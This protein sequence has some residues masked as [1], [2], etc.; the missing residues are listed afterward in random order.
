MFSH[1]SK[2]NFIFFKKNQLYFIEMQAVEI[3]FGVTE[4]NGAILLWTCFY[5]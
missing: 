3:F 2:D 1:S 5:S 4:N